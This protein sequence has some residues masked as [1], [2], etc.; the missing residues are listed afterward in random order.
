MVQLH[1]KNTPYGSQAN[2][3]ELRLASISSILNLSEDARIKAGKYL[4]SLGLPKRNIVN[5]E[6]LDWL[7]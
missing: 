3:G 5:L 1:R 7:K 6:E 2:N 4:N